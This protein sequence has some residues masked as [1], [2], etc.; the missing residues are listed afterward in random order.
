MG[1]LRPRT[2]AVGI[3][4]PARQIVRD[5][6]H[7]IRERCRDR[8]RQQ[9]RLCR[10]TP[11]RQA[12]GKPPLQWRTPRCS[13]SSRC[14]PTSSSVR[15]WISRTVAQYAG[16]R[17]CRR[18]GSRRKAANPATPS[19]CHHASGSVNPGPPTRLGLGSGSRAV[20]GVTVI[21]EAP[22]RGACSVTTPSNLPSAISGAPDIPFHSDSCSAMRPG[23]NARGA[24]LTC[25]DNKP[26]ASRDSNGTCPI[27]STLS[28]TFATPLACST[29][30]NSG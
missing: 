6:I 29:S 19:R 12:N 17:R 1:S 16:S 20:S 2:G 18:S 5:D 13:D 22:S 3:G 10:S 23:G 26:L 11:H 14:R 7:L 4:F 27:A 28:R 21:V 30:M 24:L 9:G 8:L 15:R 25:T